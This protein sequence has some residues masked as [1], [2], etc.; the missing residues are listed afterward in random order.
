MSL[1]IS[2]GAEGYR[3]V[4]ETL[5][6]RIRITTWVAGLSTASGKWSFSPPGGVGGGQIAAS[7]VI[8][9]RPSVV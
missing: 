2:K 7:S 6:Q 1:A 4:K 3:G 8:A 9:S 5:L